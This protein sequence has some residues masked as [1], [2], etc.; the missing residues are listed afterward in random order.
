VTSPEKEKTETK[1]G[2]E[3]RVGRASKKKKWVPP[4]S[5]NP[6]DPGARERQNHRRKAHATVKR[7]GGGK[8][9]N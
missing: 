6:C 1:P 5:E 2:T 4:L 3:G 9:P 8:K 7:V